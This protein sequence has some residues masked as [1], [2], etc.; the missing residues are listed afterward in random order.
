M[1]AETRLTAAKK[2]LSNGRTFGISAFGEV[3]AAKTMVRMTRDG[4]NAD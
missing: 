3:S 2:F 1:I 4:F